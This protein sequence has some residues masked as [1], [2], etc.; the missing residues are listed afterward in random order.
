MTANITLYLV[1][2]GNQPLTL[3]LRCHH[4]V[5]LQLLIF[6]TTIKYIIELHFALPFLSAEQLQLPFQFPL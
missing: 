1:I 4:N 6:A 3:S 5:K 2:K